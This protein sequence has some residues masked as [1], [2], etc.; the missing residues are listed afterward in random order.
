MDLK[1][2]ITEALNSGVVQDPT[3]KIM[4]GGLQQLNNDEIMAYLQAQL[5][6]IP[7]EAIEPAISS[8]VGTF[9]PEMQ[10]HLK[11]A[12]AEVYNFL[13]QGQAPPSA[14]QQ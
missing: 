8:L 4:L 11:Q 13:R 3:H 12:C 9:P 2:V 7:P 5:A 14:L 6:Q 1:G 10:V